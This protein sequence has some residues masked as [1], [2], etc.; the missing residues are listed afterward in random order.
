MKNGTK[1]REQKT[2]K[3]SSEDFTT[4]RV[5]RKTRD[6]INELV[7]MDNSCAGIVDR[8]VEMYIKKVRGEKK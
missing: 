7:V 6:R 8:A 1:N 3:K 4:V 2:S 5:L